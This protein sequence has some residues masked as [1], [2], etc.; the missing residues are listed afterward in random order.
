MENTESISN[1][2]EVKQD[3][4]LVWLDFDAYSYTN[5]AI[6]SELYKL[7]ESNFIGLVA[8]KQDVDF[9]SESRNYAIQKINVLSRLLH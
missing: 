6:S 5:F 7:T 4:I 1:L 8:T 2:E 9:F 3:N